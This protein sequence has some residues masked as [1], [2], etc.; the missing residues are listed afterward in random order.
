VR[1]ETKR[2]LRVLNFSMSR[3][4]FNLMNATEELEYEEP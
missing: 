2:H 4:L 1:S 3:A